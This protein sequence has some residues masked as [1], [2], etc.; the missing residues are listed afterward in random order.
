VPNFRYRDPSGRI[1][2]NESHTIED[3]NVLPTP[4]FEDLD[5]DAYFNSARI[6]PLLTSRGCYWNRCAFCSDHFTFGSKY[7][8][9]DMDRVIE[10]I[11]K[12]HHDHNMKSIVFTDQAIRAH[13][14]DQ[15]SD[16][17]LKEDLDISW[18]TFIRLEKG[19]TKSLFDNAFKA[20]C[21]II[22]VGLESGSQRVLDLMEKGITIDT[23][24]KII[25]NAHDSGIWVNVFTIIGFPGETAED[26]RMTT[27]F[28][29]QNHDIF[30]SNSMGMCVVMYGSKLYLDREKYGITLQD[31]FD[32]ELLYRREA[33]EYDVSE[34]MTKEEVLRAKDS[35][36]QFTKY[37]SFNMKFHRSISMEEMSV[38]LRR[39]NRDDYVKYFIERNVKKQKRIDKETDILRE[40]KG[41]AI[42]S[43]IPD[44]I[45][46]QTTMRGYDGK[47]ITQCMLFNE[48]VYSFAEIAGS[49]KDF[50]DLCTNHRTLNDIFAQ[51]SEKYNVP[52]DKLMN[53]FL[54]VIN[55]LLGQG[56]FNV[57]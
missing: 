4:S 27:E 28:M 2:V 37:Y 8:E 41:D 35:Y 11:K 30:D 15:L 44:V 38:W 57:S 48:K 39:Y 31:N 13:R 43:V 17:L 49:F 46:E 3:I 20:G 40:K 6:V 54:P 34:G 33:G 7:R 18:V 14:I 32:Y 29:V 26:A 10:D 16:A 19:F 24:T 1:R 55:M 53:S 42:V 12:L 5:L 50:L 56:F 21:R 22:S 51:L 52:Q 25:K 45:Y 47:E 9:R 23:A 36:D